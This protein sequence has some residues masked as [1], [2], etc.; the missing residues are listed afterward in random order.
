MHAQLAPPDPLIGAGPTTAE[1]LA[2]LRADRRDK[3]PPLQSRSAALF[4]A[5]ARS[6]LAHAVETDLPFRERLVWFWT[7][8][9]TVSTR[10]GQ[11]A[12]VLPAF[13]AEAIRPH[14]TGRFADMLGAVMR[15]PAMLIYLDNTTSI[16]PDSAAGQRSRRGLNE[17]LARECL[18]LHT[19]SP[20]AGYTQ[21]DVTA[22]AAVLTGWS[23]DLQADPPGFRFRPAAHQPGPQTVL[24][25][26]FPAG[27]AGGIAALAFLASHPAT[28]R[29]LATRLTRH[30][31]A[32][33][34][35]PA[36]IAAIE[37]VLRKTDGDLGAAAA[38][39]VG[40]PAPPAAKLRTPQELVVASLRALDLPEERRPDALAALAALGQPFWRAPAPNGWPDT[41]ADWAAPEAMVRR[42]DFAWALAGRS[43]AADPV[44]LAET[45]QGPLLDPA[46][47]RAMQRAASRREALTLFLTAPAFQRR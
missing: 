16:G 2:A 5:G 41:A 44:A 13:V 43:D 28:H 3:P 32:D 17:N 23:I 8:H 12:A 14:V 15:H 22:F 21:Q 27:E 30:F 40:V 7:N 33:D 10:R 35:P 34:P 38:A 31:V 46:T 42:I 1:G 29:H 37:A 36:A 24:G 18:E 39:L 6:Q 20:A 47:R 19:V 4:R 9:F 11:C 25:R 26:T 45:V